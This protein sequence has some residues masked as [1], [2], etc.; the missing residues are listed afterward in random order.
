[1]SSGELAINEELFESLKVNCTRPKI[2]MDDNHYKIWRPPE[3]N[4]IYVVGVDIAEGVGQN[5]TSIQVLDL[6][7]LTNIEQVATYW[8][9]VINPYNFVTKLHE[10]LLQWGSPP[11][12]IE[13]NGCGAQVVDQLYF[14]L[15]YRNVVSYDSNA[16]KIKQNRVGIH[17]H[18]NIKYKCVM[19]MR[20]FINE[21]NTVNIRDID[22]LIEIKNFIKYPSGKWAAKPGMDMLDD[23]VMSLGWGLIILDND[24]VKRYFDVVRF[25]VN[26][27]PAELRRYDYDVNLKVNSKMFGWDSNRDEDVDAI[28]FTE[29][30]GGN[31]DE[32]VAMK[33]QGWSMVGDFQTQK[34][35][36]PATDPKYNM[37]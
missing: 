29:G 12:L 3:D 13:R 8:S 2:S 7:D 21:C 27:R 33:D 31:I 18:T 1:M 6:K 28:I 20:Y 36:A 24:I 25:D 4:G 10:I 11:V 32:V 37:V 26:N 17:S 9:D 23:R 30:G 22:T 5:A 14:N 34:S 16:G 35:Y 15:G 19:N